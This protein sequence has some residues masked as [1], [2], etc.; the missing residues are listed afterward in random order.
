MHQTDK[1]TSGKDEGAFMLILGDFVILAP[2]VSLVFQVK[3]TEAICSH[4]EVV[5]AIGIA[6]FDQTGV[7]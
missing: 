7:L 5:A 3:L 4:D 2:I 6:D 1:F